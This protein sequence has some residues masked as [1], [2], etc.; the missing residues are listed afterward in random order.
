[1]KIKIENFSCIRY[2]VIILLILV[3]CK[4]DN[5]TEAIPQDRFSINSLP[6]FIEGDYT[7][8]KLR[9]GHHFQEPLKVLEITAEALDGN[10]PGSVIESGTAKQKNI[11]IGEQR[12]F[13]L[14]IRG[15]NIPEIRFK[16][17]DYEFYD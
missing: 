16:V 11:E 8:F 10:I 1:M 4:T 5:K 3:G 7:V 14:K 13:Y 17:T 9:A 6:H 2:I 15:H 12:L